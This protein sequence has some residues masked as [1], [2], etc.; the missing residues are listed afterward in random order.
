M[1][2]FFVATPAGIRRYG[3]YYKRIAQAIEKLGHEHTCRFIIDFKESILNMPE[4][5][6]GTHYQRVMKSL[7]GSDIV[8]LEVTVSSLT[9]GQL[10]Q[11]A[12]SLGKPIIALYTEGYNHSI[13]LGGTERVEA[14][15][16]VLEYV[17]DDLEQA[18]EDALDEA[19][20]WLESR[21]TLVLTP[22]MRNYLDKIAESGVS[23]S[24]YIRK[25]IQ[26]DMQ[27]KN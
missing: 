8:V 10:L 9:V 6:W 1:K 26:Q 25:L 23:R 18:V 7:A 2:V 20:D 16:Q 22:P 5:E 27:K 15:I 12:I 4:A 14:K 11:Q 13:F 17:E 24:D 19:K 3:A 21:F